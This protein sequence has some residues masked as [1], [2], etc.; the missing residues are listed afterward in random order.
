MNPLA[1]F[2]FVVA[3]PL[4]GCAGGAPRA[5]AVKTARLA[6]PAEAELPHYS[7]AYAVSPSAGDAEIASFTKTVDDCYMS[8]GKSAGAKMGYSLSPAGT[9]VP[10][11]RAE[12][13]CLSEK[14]KAACAAMLDC[15]E[16]KYGR[17]QK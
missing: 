11:S 1:I 17:T 7:R 16:K 4:C 13:S 15:V 6:I 5:A 3:L 10:F 2:A 14:G 9:A 8:A 12:V